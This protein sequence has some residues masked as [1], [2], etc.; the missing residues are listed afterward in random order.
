M[1]DYAKN[2]LTKVA[3]DLSIF[4]KEFLKFYQSLSPEQ[5]KQLVDWCIEQ[6]SEQHQLVI[7]EARAGVKD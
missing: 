6:F 5:V 4:K 7:I 1:L 3:F 2:V